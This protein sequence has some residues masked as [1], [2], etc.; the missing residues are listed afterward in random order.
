MPGRG[1]NVSRGAK[2]ALSLEN[3]TLT[4]PACRANLIVVKVGRGRLKSVGHLIRNDHHGIVPG[5]PQVNLRHRPEKRDP[6]LPEPK[7]MGKQQ[8]EPKGQALEQGCRAKQECR[9]RRAAESR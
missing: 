2:R 4:D 6:A 7:A 1:Y 3:V 9:A 5:R 8:A